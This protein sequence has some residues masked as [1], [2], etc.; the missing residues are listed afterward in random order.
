MENYIEK[1]MML[2]NK[3]TMSINYDDSQNPIFGNFV[4]FHDSNLCHYFSF[5]LPCFRADCSKVDLPDVEPEHNGLTQFGRVSA[6]MGW[7]MNS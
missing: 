7:I 5:E 1:N 4:Y 2:E 6:E 3:V